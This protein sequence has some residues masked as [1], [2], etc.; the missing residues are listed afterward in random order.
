MK[1]LTH[2]DLLQIFHR[3]DPRYD[4]RFYIGVKTTKIYCRPICSAKPKDE[5]ILFFKSS[6]EAEILGY[7][8]CLRCHPDIGPGTRL[9][10]GTGH[11]V[12]RA[13]KLM[14]KNGG[15]DLNIE[16][17]AESVGM[18]DRHLRR[19]F[20]EH[21]GASPIEILQT[22]RLH[23]AKQ[24]VQ[25]SSQPMTDIAFAVGFKSIRRFNEAYAD[26]FHCSPSK[27]R[28]SQSASGENLQL[29]LA[30]RKP[31]D[32]Q[33]VLAYLKRHEA[34]GIEQVQESLY[35]RFVPEKLGFGV[36]EVSYPLNQSY[37]DVHLKNISLSQVKPILSQL[38]H[39][40][41]ADHNPEHLAGNKNLSRS[42]IRV[43][44]SFDSFETV[45][46]IILS[47]LVST[48]QAKQ[49]LKT[50]IQSYGKKIGDFQGQDVFSFPHPQKIQNAVVEEIGITKVKASAIR[51][52][53]RMFHEG[54]DL[55]LS[56]NVDKCRQQLLAVKGIGPWT[57]EMIAMRC[58][59]DGD[60]FPSGDL[61]IQRALKAKKIDE[62]KWK[63]LRAYLTHLTWRDEAR[64][65]SKIK[66]KKS[67]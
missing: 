16:S 28:K 63:S 56:S 12:S 23:L 29:R 21:L 40:L 8:P 2:S 54:W 43:P 46:S 6:A 1:T 27:H 39:L 24:L 18:T 41:D 30:I 5:N 20:E 19:L 33:T 58:L 62:S 64:N 15:E 4:G 50:F 34:F 66:R 53:A 38:R 57:V 25:Q 65:F 10:F 55:S 9:H 32:W 59:G 26:R 13:L 45:V 37:L 35:R 7:R 51:E 11:S 42:G 36:I 14:E 52:V 17:L 22:Q 60:A 48:D 67:V 44:G 49:K 31:Y 47:Q 61:I 3:R